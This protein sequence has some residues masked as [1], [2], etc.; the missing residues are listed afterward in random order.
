MFGEILGAAGSLIGGLIGRESQE[1]IA[2]QQERIARDNMQMQKQFAQE[3][4]R[5]RVSDAQ[6]AGIHPLYALGAQIPTY[7]PSSYI[8]AEG[9]D[10]LAAG[11]AAA[12]QNIGRAIDAGSTQN[13]RDSS[14][15]AELS[16]ERAQ[17]EN[18]LL[19]AR[20]AK[21]TA[22][23]VPPKPQLDGSQNLPSAI[24]GQETGWRKGSA[25]NPMIGV[26][27]KPKEV[28]TTQMGLPTQEAGA[29]P[30]VAWERTQTGFRPQPSEA[31]NIDDADVTN[32]KALEWYWHNRVI[33][34]FTFNRGRPYFDP[35]PRSYL[36]AGAVGW[37]WSRLSQ[38]YQPVYPSKDG[39]SS[40]YEVP[41]SSFGVA[42]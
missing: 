15:L 36:P 14:R 13:E 25:S 33:P 38:E 34:T 22:N 12:S 4:I 19:R 11:L 9:G 39:R 32:L 29:I 18:D 27:V 3:G 6:A 42:P 5:W 17:L 21:E 28:P 30:G 8:P 2:N 23:P 40:G 10:P 20:I 24:P 41:P 26:K 16:L 37:R 1:D 35:P 7:S 31:L